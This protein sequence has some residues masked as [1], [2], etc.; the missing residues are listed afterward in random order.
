MIP[1]SDECVPVLSAAP[2]TLGGAH[3]DLSQL[4]PYAAAG[5]CY[6]EG[7]CGY[8]H[9][10]RCEV[11]GLQVLHPHDPEQRRAHEKVCTSFPVSPSQHLSLSLTDR[12]SVS[13]QMCLLA[14]EADMEKAFAAQLSQ[15]KVCRV[16]RCSGC[17]GDGGSNWCCVFRCVPSA[18]RWWSR[19]RTRRTAGSASCPPAV[20]PSVWPASDSGAAP[21]PSATRSSSKSPES[22][23]GSVG[24]GHGPSGLSVSFR[25]CPECRVASEFVIPS[26]YWVE[27]QDDKDHLIELFK[28][29]VR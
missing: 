13:L 4:C 16:S 11:C 21:G 15:D 17:H 5:R 7:N 25:A 28:S 1:A 27:D 29:G 2:P 8:L 19:R 9:G 23:R 3:Q 22:S 26:V 10:D 24:P 6:Y 14:F 20:T 18:W 12:L